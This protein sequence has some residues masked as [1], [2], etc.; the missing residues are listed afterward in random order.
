MVRRVA[1]IYRRPTGADP[2]PFWKRPITA[3]TVERDT[4]VGAAARWTAAGAALAGLATLVGGLAAPSTF[5]A[6]LVVLAIGLAIG[7]ATSLRISRQAGRRPPLLHA[8][9]AA[10]VLVALAAI[11]IDARDVD[12]LLAVLRGPMPNVLVLLVVLHGFEVVDRRTLR[13]H[14]A[15]TFVVAAY[16][17]GLRID[18]ALGWWL[19]MWAVAF[20]TSLLLTA[21]PSDDSSAHV[22]GRATPDRRGCAVSTRAEHS[23]DGPSRRAPA[24]VDRRVGGR[25]ARTAE[26]DPVPDGPA[27]LGLPALSNNG[28]TVASPGALGG[29]DGCAGARSRRRSRSG[30]S[31][32][33]GVVGY[34]GFTEALDTSIPRRPG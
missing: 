2:A 26:R 1:H 31:R 24:R 32:D 9:I 30:S 25:D 15:I 7:A 33:G 14:Q 20:L 12:G 23:V 29:S 8:F 27:R 19:G 28:A 4:S 16:A 6:L 13:V 3:G 10:V 22:D 21:R 11:A 17:A 5:V 18:D 34:P